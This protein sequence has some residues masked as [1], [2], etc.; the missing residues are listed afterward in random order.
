MA[1]FKFW[2]NRC[3]PITILVC[4]IIIFFVGDFLLKCRLF[5]FTQFKAVD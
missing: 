5:D 2:T 3:L 1:Y 4:P